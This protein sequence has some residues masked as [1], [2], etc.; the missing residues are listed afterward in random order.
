[1]IRRK[2]SEKSFEGKTGPA[3][4]GLIFSQ[5]RNGDIAAAPLRRQDLLQAFQSTLIQISVMA[6]LSA[7]KDQGLRIV[8]LDHGGYPC[9]IVA[10][11]SIHDADRIRI[12][13]GRGPIQS[14]G[15]VQ[16][17][18]V[19]QF[20]HCD[21]FQEFASGIS[22]QTSGKSAGAFMIVARNKYVSYIAY[23]MARMADEKLVVGN[24][25]GTDSDPKSDGDQIRAM[26]TAAEIILGTGGCI[27]GGD[28]KNRN[29]GFCLKRPQINIFTIFDPEIPP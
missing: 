19:R 15:A 6:H 1:M 18:A 14:G 26:G 4:G 10:C 12:A 5:N 3:H 7:G 16:C 17:D 24:D 23:R 29:P 21:R 22:L 8:K 11:C 28:G 9:G 2:R 25:S 20:F 27:L 13:I